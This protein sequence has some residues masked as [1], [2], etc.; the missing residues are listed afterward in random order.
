MPQRSVQ[1][2]LLIRITDAGE[3]LNE[4][5]SDEVFEIHGYTAM[6]VSDWRL[7]RQLF[8]T[9]GPSFLKLARELIIK[10]RVPRHDQFHCIV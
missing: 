7:R 5:L 4:S 9:D 10:L 1:S 6:L 3:D 2:T 8:D